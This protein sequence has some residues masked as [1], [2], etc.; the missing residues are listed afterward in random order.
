[1][2]PQFIEYIERAIS[3]QSN[4]QDFDE[5]RQKDNLEQAYLVGSQNILAVKLKN[6]CYCLQSP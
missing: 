6:F 2:R 3:K 5:V 1:M 4:F